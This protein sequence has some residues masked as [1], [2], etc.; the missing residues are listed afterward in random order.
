M[1]AIVASAVVSAGAVAAACG[2]AR[3]EPAPV[4]DDSCTAG[5]EALTPLSD[6]ATLAGTYQLSLAASSGARAGAAVDG[7]L[8]LGPVDDA[9]V[10]PVLVLGRPDSTLRH[11]LAGTLELDPASLGAVSTGDF[12]SL[13]P[14]A[15]GVLVIERRPVGRQAAVEITLRLGAEANRGGPARMDGGYFAL[16]VRRLGADGFAGTWRSGGAPGN[17]AAGSF[18]ARHTAP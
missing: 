1:T 4:A 12:A 9:A 13:D 8:V 10:A 16:T 11:P 14:A 15:P 5:G 3:S 7:R 2:T 18:C 6:A 17:E